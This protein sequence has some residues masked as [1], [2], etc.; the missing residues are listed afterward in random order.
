MTS[1]RPS[2]RRTPAKPAGADGG[3][4]DAKAIY[5]RQVIAIREAVSRH[6]NL[7]KPFPDLTKAS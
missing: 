6:S 2:H 4:P 7:T 5:G 1:E 3:K